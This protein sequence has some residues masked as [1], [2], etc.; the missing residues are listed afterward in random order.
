[1]PKFEDVI[2]MVASAGLVI[3]AG[4]WFTTRKASAAPS[5]ASTA[6]WLGLSPGATT[7]QKQWDSI[8]DSR[9][10]YGVIFTQGTDTAGQAI[11]VAHA[12]TQGGYQ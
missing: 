5:L 11:D 7:A 12:N 2:V 10:D 3:A 9:S 6:G 8:P 1:M 4:V